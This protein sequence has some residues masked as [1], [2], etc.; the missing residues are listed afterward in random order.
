MDE[1]LEAICL[2]ILHR[3]LVRFAYEGMPRTVEPFC[4]GA[5]TAGK[6]VVR[7][8]QT[9]GRSRSGE[10]VG[11]KLFD[12]SGIADLTI[13]D[14]QFDY[15]SDYNPNDPSIVSIYCRV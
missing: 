15:R 1:V 11:W 9:G 5:S 3:R 12:V 14:A 4:C 10:P 13:V 7:G 2:A 8:Y 6:D